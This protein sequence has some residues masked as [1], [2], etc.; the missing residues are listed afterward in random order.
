MDY[1]IIATDLDGTLLN[2]QGNVSPENW[3]AIRK[4]QELGVLVVPTTG[5][6]F[7]ELSLQ[8]RESPLFRYYITSGGAAIYDKETGKNYDLGIPRLLADEV[9]DNGYVIDEDS[10]EGIMDFGGNDDADEFED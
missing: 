8:L 9:L 2:S 3:E 10:P 6:V 1:K 4:L 5:R 7:E